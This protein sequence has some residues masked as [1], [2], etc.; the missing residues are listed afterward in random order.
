MRSSRRAFLIG[1][2]ACAL[3]AQAAPARER[4]PG[5]PG[6]DPRFGA[7][8]VRIN[9]SAVVGMIYVDLGQNFLYHVLEPG[10]ARRYGVALGAEGRNLVGEAY[11]G[12]KAEW[13]PW[14]PTAE[15]IRLEPA[16]YGPYRN[17]LPGG[18]A[19]N[20]LGA[21]AL[22]LYRGG[23]DTLVRIHGT[24]QPWTI[25]MKFSSGCIRLHNDHVIELYDRVPI[26]TR[27]LAFGGT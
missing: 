15:M 2:A 19:M 16:V 12:R 22:Y 17:G 1:S 23:R 18:H 7:H 11:V 20:P 10:V 3:C 24:P 21:R 9:G 13:P 4:T 5:R 6:V 14:R 26:G 27:V 25:G 8:T